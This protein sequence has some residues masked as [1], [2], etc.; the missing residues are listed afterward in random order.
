MST[1][2]QD[3][4]VAVG[5]PPES[6]RDWRWLWIALA[7]LGIVLAL[8][9]WQ[10]AERIGERAARKLQDAETRNAG[11]VSQLQG[12]QDNLR[13][14]QG[15]LA[16]VENRLSETAGQ[17]QQ[18]E[19]MYRSMAQNGLE[20]VL[21][22]VENAVSIASQ[23]L[24][25][26]ANVQGAI[27][28]LQD[29]EARIKGVDAAS[30]GSLRR[31]LL[32]D[33]ERLKAVPSTDLVS[34]LLRV[35]NVLQSIDALPLL[36]QFG[37]ANGQRNGLAAPALKSEPAADAATAA[38]APWSRLQQ[39][40]LRSLSSFR[41]ELQSLV[42]VNRVDTP[43]ALLLAPEQSY[44]VRENFRLQL[45][46]ARAALLARQDSVF[47][48]DVDRASRWLTSYFDTKQP[49]VGNAITQL[50]QLQATRIS[51]DMPSLAETLSAIRGLRAGRNP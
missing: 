24:L 43:E 7:V 15:R 39:S 13:E 47:R 11:L 22:D 12:A 4:A 14:M 30:L 29:A 33:I 25:V 49:A 51:V 6:K 35:D 1:T 3:S 40:S 44:F 50:K 17:Q 34:L 36:A 31:L 21:A 18:L 8:A 41:Q 38:D 27:L 46:N 48:S 9:A 5:V 26:G 19:R 16:I 37:P 45:L 32:R 2:P 23:Q 42:R 20:A 10:R 28:V